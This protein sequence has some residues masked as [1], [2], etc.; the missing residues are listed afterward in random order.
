MKIGNLFALR[1]VTGFCIRT[2]VLGI[3]M[4][5]RGAKER[6]IWLTPSRLTSSCCRDGVKLLAPCIIHNCGYRS[7]EHTSELQDAL[8]IEMRY[9]GAKE[10][11]IWLTPSR[12]T[13]SCCRDGVKLLAPCII[14]NCGY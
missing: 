2:W 12:L 1:W 6:S 3:Q 11:S 5:Y 8:R 7:E 14:H 4:R 9:R 10:R 13:S